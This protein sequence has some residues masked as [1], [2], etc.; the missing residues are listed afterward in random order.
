MVARALVLIAPLLSTSLASAAPPKQLGENIHQSTTVGMDATRD[1]GLG[2]VR[3]DMNWFQ[4]Q[5]TSG[6]PD[7]TLLDQVVDAAVARNLMVLGVL[8]YTPAWASSGDTKGDGPSNDLPMAGTYPAFVTLAVDHF[9]DRVTHYELW[10]EPNLGQFFEGTP[11]DYAGLIL[12][13][14]ADAVHAACAT[15]QV[16][17]PAL[18]SVGTEYATWLD[19]SLTAA[20]DKIDI[21]SGHIYASFVDQDPG[22]G[23]T[24]DS[25]FNKLESHRIIKLGQTVVYE[26]PLSFKEVMDQHGATQPLWI[27]ETGMEAAYG[28]ATAEGKQTVYYR[29]VLEAMLTRPWWTTTIFYEGFDEP[30][31]GTTWGMVLDDPNAP[32]G[33]DAKPVFDLFQ[34]VTGAQPLFG[35]SGFDCSDG[36]DNDGDGKVDFPDDTDCASAMGPSE[37]PQVAQP[38]LAMAGDGAAALPDAASPGGDGGVAPARDLEAGGAANDLAGDGGGESSGGCA[39]SGR[40]RAPGCAALLVLLALAGLARSPRRRRGG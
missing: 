33:Y 37:S 34:K 29:H 14:G 40:G 15:C 36:L 13:P 27:D 4:M 6:A 19:A 26:G 11:Q 38:D 16:V 2:W 1:A 22:A 32:A 8:A 12:A 21:V 28:H 35:G 31:G 23:L 3:V 9:K 17:A 24:A 25:Y 10:N 18:A 30:N 20:G 7:F 5:P 39:L